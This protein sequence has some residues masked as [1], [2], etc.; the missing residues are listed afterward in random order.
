MRV[1]LWRGAFAVAFGIGLL[2]CTEPTGP[3]AVQSDLAV[4]HDFAASPRPALVISQVY[5]GG[6]NSGATLK[7]DFIEVFNP[8]TVAVSVTGWSV[9]YNSAGGILTWQVTPLSGS[10]PAGGYYLIQEVAGTGGTT[11]LPTPDATGTIPLSGTAGK[12]A[13]SSSTTAFTGAC[14]AGT[15]DEVSFGTQTAAC[16]TT[17]SNL[18]N[19]TSASRNSAGC[20]LTGS[21]SAD[22]S[23]GT[24]APRNSA[25]AVNVCPA[26]ALPAVTVTIAPNPASSIVG[27]TQTFTATARDSANNVTS[28]SFTWSSTNTSVATITSAGVASALTAG[29]TLIKAVSTN[30]KRDSVTFTVSAAPTGDVVISQVYGGGGNSGAPYTNDYVELFN[31]GTEPADITGWL[32]QYASSSASSWQSTPLSGTIQPGH[33]YLVQ[34]SAGAGTFTALPTPD[35]TG[36]INMSGTS[37]KVM[38]TIPGFSSGVACPGGAAVIDKVAYGTSTNCSGASDWNGNTNTLSNTTA[39]FRK[40]DGCTKTGNITNDFVVLPPNPHNSTSTKNCV[41]PARVQSAATLVINELMGDPANAAGGPSWGEWFEVYNYGATPINLNGWKIISGGTS[42]PDHTISHDVIVPAGGY[43]VLGRGNDIAQN[44]GVTL[45]YN[46]FTGN[47]TTIWLDDSDYLELVDN[48]DARV[49]SVAWTSLPHGVTRGL[50]DASLA[51]ADVNGTDWGYSSTVFGDGDYGTPDADNAPLVDVA[52]I[53]SANKITVSGRVATDA[54]LPIGFEAQIFA[55]EATDGGVP[56]PTTFTFSSLTPSLAS[57]DALG[58]IH[59]LG[60]GFAR[61]LITA[62]DGTA[63][64]HTLEMSTPVASATAQYLDNEAFGEPTDADASDD[65]IIH[66]PQYTTSFNG[67]RGIPNWV[68]YDLNGTDISSGQD[69]CNCFTFDP[70]LIAAGFTRYTTADYTGAGAFAGYGIDR[71]HMTRSFDRTAGTL[72][73]ARTFYFSNVVPQAADLN[74][75]PWANFENYLGDLATLQNKE[76]YIYVGPAGSIGT[77]KDEGKITIPKYTWKIALVLP[78]GAGLADVHDYRDVQQVIAVVMPNIAGVRN[79]DW[80]TNYVVTVDSVERLTHYKFLSALDARTQRAL[81]TNTKPPLGSVDGPYNAAE[82]TSV[83]MS[84]AGSI[85]PNGSIV[86]YQWNFGDGNTGSGTTVSHTYTHYGAYSVRMIV[87][88]NDGLVDTVATTATIPAQPPTAGV[89]GP[90]SSHEGSSVSMSAAS[91]SDPDGTLV[92]YEWDFG[93]GSTGSGSSV[94]HSYAHAGSYTVKVTVTD[95]DA[96]A[97]TATTTAVIAPTPPVGVVNGPYSSNEGS[98]VSMSGAGSSDANGSIVSYEWSFG[99]G[100]TGSGSSVS[101]TYATY[102]SYNVTLTVTDND[103][104]TDAVS[105]TTT[106]ANVSPVVLPFS[107]ATILPGESYSANG[108]FTD[109]GA[110]TWS[111]TVNYGDGSGTQSLALLNKTFSLSHT[112]MTAG[113]FTTTASV[114]DGQ[115]TGNGTATVTVLSPGQGIGSLQT[116]LNQLIANGTIPQGNG[117]SLGSKL[118]AASKQLSLGNKTAAMNQLQAFV[119][120]VNAMV[121]SGRLSSAQADALD[122]WVSRIIAAMNV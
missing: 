33:Y 30:G 3:T 61:F 111:G 102:G 47:A 108:S 87:T 46:Y 110:E 71:G 79:V 13:I 54:P 74:Q 20:A 50:R 78:R 10:I 52:P 45:D 49:D 57:I 101:H 56:I 53:V 51:H 103:G 34:E 72:D 26:V 86:S 29:T 24:A 94:S 42:Q 66:R 99:D 68:A 32:I 43:A 39:A 16:G 73:N 96:L 82:N 37:A 25:T 115:L 62:A 69:R 77:L 81:K 114:S 11:S 59:S 90:Y 60:A 58:V 17:T 19:T 70:E 15:V 9:Q 55:S 83:N 112:Y 6:G 2:S 5:G 95:N 64:V 107:G 76:V 38:L 8:G 4:R 75:G 116:L 48:A 35:A 80:A 22:F 119:N 65:F 105:T 40:I 63:R 88:D 85:D 21:T 91:S 14:P 27:G 18:S 12:V 44:G 97:N 36:S 7:N 106:V 1:N 31:R 23:V 121:Q 89:D 84:G 28:T 98:S 100:S 92:S 109:P 122:A 93:D 118:S 113:T 120:E 117:N 104:W 67:P 41:A